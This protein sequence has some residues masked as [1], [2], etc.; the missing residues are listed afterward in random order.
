MKRHLKTLSPLFFLSPSVLPQNLAEGVEVGKPPQPPTSL[1]SLLFYLL[2][3]KIHSCPGESLSAL[4]TQGQWPSASASL[5]LGKHASERAGQAPVVRVSCPGCP[6][7]A[8]LGGIWL[9]ARKWQG[10]L[11]S[12]PGC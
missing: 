1:Q 12:Y 11:A 10:P 6:F 4:H 8:C 3:I 9:L 2:P 5:L 7:N